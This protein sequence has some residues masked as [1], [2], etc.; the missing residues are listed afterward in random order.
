MSYEQQHHS[1]FKA[2]IQDHTI[3]AQNSVEVLKKKQGQTVQDQE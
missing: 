2:C 1:E 3:L